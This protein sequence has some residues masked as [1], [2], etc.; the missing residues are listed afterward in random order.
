MAF[1]DKAR[2]KDTINSLENY[3]SLLSVN[4]VAQLVGVAPG[5]VRK[6]SNKGHLVPVPAPTNNNRWFRPEDVIDLLKKIGEPVDHTW[7][8]EIHPVKK[9]GLCQKK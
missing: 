2:I 3:N 7:S 6:W 9:G 1:H 8:Q 4:E 5:T